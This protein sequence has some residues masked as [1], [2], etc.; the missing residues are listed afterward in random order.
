MFLMLLS[1]APQIIVVKKFFKLV[2]KIVISSYRYYFYLGHNFNFAIKT[3]NSLATDNFLAGW[4]CCI[5]NGLV[6]YCI[7]CDIKL[8]FFIFLA[9]SSLNFSKTVYIY[10]H[11]FSFIASYTKCILLFYSIALNHFFRQY[12]FI[13]ICR[14]DS[15]R[16][17]SN[18]ASSKRQTWSKNSNWNR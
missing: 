7:A 1:H 5:K 15:Q 17:Y 18:P 16:P 11:N 10:S 8:R 4:A 6:S 9:S 2:R 13:F 3:D 14:R 12:L